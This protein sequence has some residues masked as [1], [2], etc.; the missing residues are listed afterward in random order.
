ML[1]LFVGKTKNS[2]IG[3]ESSFCSTE[4]HICL[5]SCMSLTPCGDLKRTDLHTGESLC[6]ALLFYLVK[7][8]LDRIFGETG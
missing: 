1:P 5:N 3:R 7:L 6:A 4:S 2:E 8:H